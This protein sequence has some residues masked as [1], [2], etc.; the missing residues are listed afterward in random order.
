[1]VF[2]FVKQSGGHIK[3][4]SE[5]GHGTAIKIY[6]P[7]ADASLPEP[8]AFARALDAPVRGRGETILVVEDD[9]GV[10]SFIVTLLGDLG[11]GVREAEDGP[12]ALEWL[13]TGRIPDL[14]LSDVVLPKSMNGPALARA[15]RALAPE[16]KVLFMSGYTHD[17]LS[18][19][20]A[21]DDAVN[22]ITKP[23]RKVDLAAKIRAV[24]DGKV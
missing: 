21:V 24:L 10:R 12:L 3:V 5:P 17:A 16:L 6:L 9:G 4:Y 22:I 15:A 7:R 20:G 19:E 18:R 11:Y 23:F 14:L 2:G 1:M 8:T 13:S